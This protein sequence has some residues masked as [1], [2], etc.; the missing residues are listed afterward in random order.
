MF[1]F[2]SN[3]H[4]CSFWKTFNMLKPQD[5]WKKKKGEANKKK[6]KKGWPGHG[7]VGKALDSSD[8]NMWREEGQA[9]A[10]PWLQMAWRGLEVRMGQGV[11]LPDSFIVPTT[12]RSSLS[13]CHLLP[14]R[15]KDHPKKVAPPHYFPLHPILSTWLP[16]SP[17]YIPVAHPTLGFLDL[18]APCFCCLSLGRDLNKC[19]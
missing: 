8:S 5:Y 17:D 16:K 14:C 11:C 15:R 1:S 6:K 7:G 4:L 19:C 13:P 3:I 12:R 2:F 9:A 18:P 10:Q